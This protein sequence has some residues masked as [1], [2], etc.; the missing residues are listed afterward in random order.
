MS[1]FGLRV[2]VGAQEFRVI[3]ETEGRNWRRNFRLS[4]EKTRFHQRSIASS[5]SSSR[6]RQYTLMIARD[7][8]L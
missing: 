8:L 1:S 5:S 6:N 2:I 4:K 3:V 7:I